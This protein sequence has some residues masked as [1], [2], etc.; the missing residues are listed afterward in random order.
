MGP[1]DPVSYSKVDTTGTLI[2]HRVNPPIK[3]ISVQTGI[4]AYRHFHQHELELRIGEL[5]YFIC[6]VGSVY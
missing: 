2:E 3:V 1:G 5:P 6:E 4:V